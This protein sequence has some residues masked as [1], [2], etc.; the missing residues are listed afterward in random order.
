MLPDPRDPGLSGAVDRHLR[1]EYGKAHGTPQG[2]SMSTQSMPI[3]VFDTHGEAEAAIRTLSRSGFDVKTLSLIGKGYHSE[4]KALGFYSTGDRVLAWGG[5]GA[6]WGGMWGLLV[7]PAIFLLPGLG[8][9]AMAGPV[10]T[11]LVTG[12]E[13]AVVV[14][15]LSALGAA[16][17]RIG[18]PEDEVIRYESALKAEKYILMVH[19]DAAQADAARGA[20]DSQAAWSLP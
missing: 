10:V 5:M 9:V 17:T 1:D 2:S 6:F 3:Y 11:A 13:G 8:L 4:D 14:G 15:G 20:L 19:G 7:A 12:L 18:V 16:F